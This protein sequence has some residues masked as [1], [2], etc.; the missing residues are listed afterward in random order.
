MDRWN[1]CVE[2][3]MAWQQTK[4]VPKITNN[5]IIEMITLKYLALLWKMSLDIF[6]EMNT[7]LAALMNLAGKQGGIMRGGQLQAHL[8]EHDPWCCG[9]YP[10]LQVAPSTWQSIRYWLIT[11]KSHLIKISVLETSWW[12]LLANSGFYIFWKN[13]F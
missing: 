6:I 12:W 2:H 10:Y 7:N 13:Y 1:R 9:V 11:G 5:V 4:T 3:P 8:H